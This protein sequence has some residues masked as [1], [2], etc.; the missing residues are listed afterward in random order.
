[1]ERPLV[2]YCD[3]VIRSCCLLYCHELVCACMSCLLQCLSA[4]AS[5]ILP[6]V[7][8]SF[9]IL[10]AS[11]AQTQTRANSQNTLKGKSTKAKMG[12]EIKKD[13]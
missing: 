5:I 13:G 1:M 8:H 6:F 9:G 4:S 12:L 2:Y 7:A 11:N 10:F 3:A